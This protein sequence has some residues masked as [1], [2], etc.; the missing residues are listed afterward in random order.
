MLILQ[1]FQEMAQKE[2]GM[3]D[4]TVLL[5][6]DHPDDE[7]LMLRALHKA[8]INR[9]IVKHDGCEALDFLRSIS[10]GDNNGETPPPELIIIDINMPIMNGIEMLREMR[11]DPSLKKLPV[12]VLTSSLN[13]RDIENC[14]ELG[15]CAYL[16]KPAEPKDIV[17]LLSKLDPPTTSRSSREFG[18]S[19]PEKPAFPLYL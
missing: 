16:S 17:H 13:P 2:T 6:E 3:S 14:M 4:K 18:E 1:R 10:G 12:A 19:S 11:A 9:V 15:I 8:R 5:V 7:F